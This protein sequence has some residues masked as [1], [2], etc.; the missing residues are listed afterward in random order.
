[1]CVCT[2][3]GYQET[4]ETQICWRLL[5]IRGVPL[6]LA[7][8]KMFTLKWFNLRWEQENNQI[9]CSILNNNVV[10][11]LYFI[12]QYSSCIYTTKQHN[13]NDTVVKSYFRIGLQIWSFFRPNLKHVMFAIVAFLL[14]DWMQ[15]L[16][17]EYFSKGDCNSDEINKGVAYWLTRTRFGWF[18]SEFKIKFYI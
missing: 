6:K 5:R 7:Y 12:V 18:T 14:T 3:V 15:L 4:F 9:S 17:N 1:M 8:F 2:N 11:S 10:I 13:N 16:W